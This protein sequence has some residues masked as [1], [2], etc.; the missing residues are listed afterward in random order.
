MLHLG[1][2]PLSTMAELWRP[3]AE[4]DEVCDLT[5]HHEGSW[6]SALPPLPPQ[7]QAV[8]ASEAASVADLLLAADS[9]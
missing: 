3:T 2:P 4:R 6:I 1:E 7:V 9:A 8:L 5:V